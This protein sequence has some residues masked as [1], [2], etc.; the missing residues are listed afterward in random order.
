MPEASA[1][2]QRTL[3]AVVLIVI[4]TPALAVKPVLPPPPEQQQETQ[5]QEPA[6]PVPTG[7]PKCIQQKDTFTEAKTF[8]IE[9]S[10]A[11]EQR[12]RC[13][14]HAYVV[15]SRGPTKGFATLTLAPASK[16]AAAHRSYVMK[17]K[18]SYGSAEVSRSC[19]V[20]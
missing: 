15:N 7:K 5:Q 9:L 18:E 11:C 14:V 10:N 4:A 8:V 6:V 2:L 17:L 1:V 20:L 19:K 12:M 13:T 16:G 3:L